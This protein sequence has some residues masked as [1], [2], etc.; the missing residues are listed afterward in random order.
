MKDKKGKATPHAE[1][2]LDS[3]DPWHITPETFIPSPLPYQISA[4]SFTLLRG[5][6]EMA[7][8]L[9]AVRQTPHP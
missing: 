8:L 9:Q 4:A 7:C 3:P 2:G 1:L 5:K 6:S